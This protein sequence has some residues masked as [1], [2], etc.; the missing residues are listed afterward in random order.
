M[1]MTMM[2]SHR[3]F[4][5]AVSEGADGRRAPRAGGRPAVI[6]VGPSGSNPAAAGTDNSSSR[7]AAGGTRWGNAWRSN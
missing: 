4:A 6:E 5:A 3:L 1:S 2:I 7:R